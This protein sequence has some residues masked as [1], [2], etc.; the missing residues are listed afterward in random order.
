MLRLVG[1]MGKITRV[2][3][4]VMLAAL[5]LS[6]EAEAASINVALQPDQGVYQVGETVTI[7][8]VADTADMLVGFGFDLLVD[9]LPALT[10]VGFEAADGFAGVGTP[11]GDG[12]AGLA[13]DGGLS[14]EG[15]ALGVATFVATQV[16][17]VSI[18]PAVT[19]GDLTEGFARS[20]SGFSEL[21]GEAAQISVI[22]GFNPVPIIGTGGDTG[23]G[24]TP[25]IPEPATLMLLAAG[26]FL[27]RRR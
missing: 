19:A 17:N 14:G 9:P 24:T 3:V 20:G 18:T 15:F 26:A 7:D 1:E 12:I 22:S 10:F 2:G 27:I 13:F 11:D 4:L 8:V 23:G 6:L 25:P 5:G 21:L 16:G